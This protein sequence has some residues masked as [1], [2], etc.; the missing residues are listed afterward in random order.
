MRASVVALQVG[1][2]GGPHTRGG[3]SSAAAGAYQIVGRGNY[4]RGRSGTGSI[5]WLL[6]ADRSFAQ[7]SA[8]FYILGIL[9]SASR[10]IWIHSM[11][12]TAIEVLRLILHFNIILD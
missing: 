8:A 12:S 4:G 10:L 11:S 7:I 1:S 6:R 5:N 2:D 3:L 9:R